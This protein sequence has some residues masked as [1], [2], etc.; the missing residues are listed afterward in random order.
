MK[1]KELFNRKKMKLAAI[2]L[3]T[4]TFFSCEIHTVKTPE[5]IIKQKKSDSTYSG[6]NGHDVLQSCFFCELTIAMKS[7]T[8]RSISLI[9]TLDY[10]RDTTTMNI[11]STFMSEDSGIETDNFIVFG[12]DLKREVYFEFLDYKNTFKQFEIIHNFIFKDTLYQIKIDSKDSCWIKKEFPFEYVE[13][14]K[15]EIIKRL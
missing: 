10:F 12:Y 3:T 2:L 8:R 13:F 7:K 1:T 15:E 14:K 6:N 5:V 11:G 4:L 9:R